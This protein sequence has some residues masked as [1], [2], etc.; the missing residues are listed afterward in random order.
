[1]CQQRANSAKDM[2]TALFLHIQKF[3]IKFSIL[4]AN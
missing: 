1:M 4:G 2:P 3:G